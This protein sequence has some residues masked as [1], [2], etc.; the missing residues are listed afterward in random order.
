MSRRISRRQFAAATAM[1]S[2]AF[3][4]APHVRSAYVAG[5]LSIGLWDHFVPEANKASG[6]L[7]QEWAAK[8]KVEVQIDYITTQGNKLLL[9][10]AAE[11]QARAGHDILAMSTWRPHTHAEQLEPVNDIME[12]IIKQNGEVNSVVQYLGQVNGRWMAVP[13]T[14]GS[15]IQASCSRIDLMKKYAGIDVQDMYPAGGPPRA[16][17]WTTETFLK[18]AEACHRGGFPFG[19]GLGETIDSV[20][21]AGAF[22]Q[23]FGA[24]LVD[25]HGKITVRTDEV[26]QALEFYRKLIG[27]LP[28]DVAAWDDASNN[29]WLISGRGALIMNAP[30]AWAVAKRDAPQIA[31]QCWTHGFP[32]G[33]K[34]RFAPYLPFFW[35]IWEFSKNKEAAKSLLVHLSQPSSIERMVVASGGYDLPAYEKFTTLKIWAEAEPPKGT[36][37]HYPNPYNHQ[38]LSIAASPAP[39]KI[40]LQINVQATLTKMC[41][42]Y[43]QGEAVERVLAWAEGECEGF[44]RT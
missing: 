43:A 40:A 27:L 34:G 14:A 20:A 24:Q 22:F 38:K 5:K 11:A 25:A 36:L 41:L 31:A 12:P 30:S 28:P 2:V 39:P 9:T 13:A 33:P 37:Y 35:A 6:D 8:E 15:Q 21:A 4:A 17:N 18:V 29:K 26:R 10:I 7:I 44:M 19:I 16:D 32:A 42:R 3:F 23:S 1:S